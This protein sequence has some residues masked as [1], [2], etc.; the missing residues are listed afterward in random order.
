MAVVMRA[1]WH[2]GP[3]PCDCGGW[4]RWQPGAQA[5]AWACARCALAI[6]LT[7]EQV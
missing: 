7:Q 5:N 1:V 3:V 2:P 4:I 6:T